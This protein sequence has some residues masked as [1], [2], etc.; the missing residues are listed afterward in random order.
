LVHVLAVVRRW[1]SVPHESETSGRPF[2]S[3]PTTTDRPAQLLR[4][5]RTWWAFEWVIEEPSTSCWPMCLGLFGDENP[6]H[7]EL[8][9]F[10]DPPTAAPRPQ[11]VAVSLTGCTRRGGRSSKPPWSRFFVLVHKL[12]VVRLWNP[13]HNIEIKRSIDPPTAA[14][15]QRTGPPSFSG[16]TTRGGRSNESSWSRY[17][18]LV[19]VLGFVRRWNSVPYRDKTTLQPSHSGPTT[20]DR[21]GQLLRMHRTWWAFERVIVE[22]VF[23]VGPCACVCAVVEIGPTQR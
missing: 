8:K 12:A 15:R 23:R 18:V 21:C 6:P 20:T 17:F 5:H 19:H 11:F 22:P 1:N 14:P 9:Q 16:F 10:I 7:R 4:M 2:H 3:G 13:S